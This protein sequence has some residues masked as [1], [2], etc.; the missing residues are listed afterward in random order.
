MDFVGLIY[1]LILSVCSSTSYHIFA[2]SNSSFP[3][4]HHC[5]EYPLT[6]LRTHHFLHREQMMNFNARVVISG[7]NHHLRVRPLIILRVVSPLAMYFFIS[8]C[9]KISAQLLLSFLTIHCSS[10]IRSLVWLSRRHSEECK[11]I[12]IYAQLL[13]IDRAPC[14]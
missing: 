4:V 1:L 7:L 8:V 10:S 6:R 5:C 13:L 12:S 3:T 2:T 11:L 9:G 14:E